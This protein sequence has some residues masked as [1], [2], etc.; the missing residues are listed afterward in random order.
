MTTQR[1]YPLLVAEA[2]EFADPGIDQGYRPF[3]ADERIPG[4]KE[5]SVEHPFRLDAEANPE[6]AR[7]YDDWV[8]GHGHVPGLKCYPEFQCQ[9]IE[10]YA[11]GLIARLADALASS[12]QG[13]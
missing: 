9:A 2:K 1:D 10:G 8:I 6:Q 5:R 12:I 11:H 3:D 7:A 13:R 4:W